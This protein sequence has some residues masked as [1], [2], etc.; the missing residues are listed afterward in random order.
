MTAGNTKKI[1][2]QG[3]IFHF[4]SDRYFFDFVFDEEMSDEMIYEF[5]AI[6]ADLHCTGLPAPL[7]SSISFNKTPEE[8]MVF[9]WDLWVNSLDKSLIT[10]NNKTTLIRILD[11]IHPTYLAGLTLVRSDHI[12]RFLMSDLHELSFS[13]SIKRTELIVHQAIQNIEVDDLKIFGTKMNKGLDSVVAISFGALSNE[14]IDIKFKY[15]PNIESITE[16]EIE[17]KEAVSQMEGFWF[18]TQKYFKADYWKYS[19]HK[20]VVL[21]CWYGKT[22]KSQHS[23]KSIASFLALYVN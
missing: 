11:N 5:F 22:K 15:I 9:S 8:D 14:T 6:Y 3:V 18:F 17:L 2:F 12:D 1:Q 10:L 19:G 4:A 7:I 20:E 16:Q 23:L 13:S 21:E